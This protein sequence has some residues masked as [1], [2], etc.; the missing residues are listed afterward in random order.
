M[1]DISSTQL[2]NNTDEF[3]NQRKEKVLAQVTPSEIRGV[4][5][6][7]LENGALSVPASYYDDAGRYY[8]TTS[9]HIFELNAVSKSVNIPASQ[10]SEAVLNV[11][12]RFVR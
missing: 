3:S 1:P 7:A 5:L 9:K 6:S 2:P 12:N 10:Y 8:T 11:S 4:G